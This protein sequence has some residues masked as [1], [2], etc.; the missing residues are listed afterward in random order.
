MEKEDGNSINSG[1]GQKQ[2]FVERFENGPLSLILSN[3]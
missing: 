2:T 3:P 1:Q